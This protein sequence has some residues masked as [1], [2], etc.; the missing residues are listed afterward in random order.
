MQDASCYIGCVCVY[1]YVTVEKTSRQSVRNQL[2]GGA[3]VEGRY[4]VLCLCA[5]EAESPLS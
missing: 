2:D 3:D 1:M 5:G 4:T